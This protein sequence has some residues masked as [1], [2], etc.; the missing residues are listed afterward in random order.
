MGKCGHPKYEWFKPR[1]KVDKGHGYSGRKV[2]RRKVK[3]T[4]R[5]SSQRESEARSQDRWVL[6][7][8]NWKIGS[9]T[10]SVSKFVSCRES[11]YRE[12]SEANKKM[13]RTNLYVMV[14]KERGLGGPPGAQ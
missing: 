4:G 10:M 12:I 3:K 8:R 14:V 7:P 11:I 2:E 6:L 5:Q 1:E 9:E 13:S